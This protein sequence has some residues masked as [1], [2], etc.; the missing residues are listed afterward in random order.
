[1]EVRSTWVE[2]RQQQP[3]C[4]V[5]LRTLRDAAAVSTAA[6]STAAVSTGE[7]PNMPCTLPG[8]SAAHR[9]PHQG[10]GCVAGA[11]CGLWLPHPLLR[12][13][14]LGSEAAAR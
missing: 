9:V 5:A 4:Q 2:G 12:P 14:C 3:A 13:C 6:V 11:E 7:Q 10:G 1:M 8:P